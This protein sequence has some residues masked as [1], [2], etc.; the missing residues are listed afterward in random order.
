MLP[1]QGGCTTS[2]CAHEWQQSTAASI[3]QI[4]TY[5]V[6]HDQCAQIDLFRSCRFVLLFSFIE[7]SSPFFE[8]APFVRISTPE[9]RSDHRHVPNKCNDILWIIE[10]RID[11]FHQ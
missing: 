6:L 7:I 5:P 2:V 3:A 9:I 11:F 1:A 8:E 4:D 10:I